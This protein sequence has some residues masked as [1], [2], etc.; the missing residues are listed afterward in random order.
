MNS[1]TNKETPLAKKT[2]N[3]NIITYSM[4]HIDICDAELIII[5]IDMVNINDT[6]VPTFNSDTGG[7]RYVAITKWL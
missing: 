6:E 2:N 7:S 3:K 4:Q 5:Y 1:F